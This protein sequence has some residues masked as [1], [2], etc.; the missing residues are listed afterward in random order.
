MFYGSCI[1]ALELAREVA[2]ARRAHTNPFK[3]FCLAI[4]VATLAGCPPWSPKHQ[5]L[6][7]TDTEGRTYAYLFNR[8][9]NLH[10][11]RGIVK[12]PIPDV[13]STRVTLRAHDPNVGPVSVLFGDLTLVAPPVS[14][15]EGLPI[16]RYGWRELLRPVACSRD[17]ECPDKSELFTFT[18]R[19]VRSMCTTTE[20]DTVTTLDSVI[21]RCLAH[22]GAGAGSAQQLQ[23]LAA[24]ARVCPAANDDNPLCTLPPEC[25]GP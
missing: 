25:A 4:T 11:P 20:H 15:T 22:T 23:R 7:L 5:A 2:M 3:K 1:A 14:S 13:T 19:C 6:R 9:M 18:G 8:V 16:G 24:V 21:A 12:V 17:E 10:M